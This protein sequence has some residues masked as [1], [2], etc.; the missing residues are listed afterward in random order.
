[1]D[2]EFKREFEKLTTD[3]GGNDESKDSALRNLFQVVDK[4]SKVI[5]KREYKRADGNL[6]GTSKDDE[7]KS[8]DSDNCLSS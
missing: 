6:V 3:F 5:Y 8:L 7:S 2:D 1:L 4:G